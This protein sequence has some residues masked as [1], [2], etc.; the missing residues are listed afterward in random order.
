LQSIY[1]ESMGL[2][3]GQVSIM[4]AM[5]VLVGALGRIVVGAMTDRFGGRIMFSALLL[6]GVPAVLL[7]AVAGSIGSYP[8]LLV[9][10]F[11]LGIPGTIFAV[12]IPF[13]S[14][15]FAPHRR[16]FATG[17]FGMGMIG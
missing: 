8:L 15:W 12:G 10:A 17:V 5:P 9:A 16:G 6:M 13:S 2:D 14:A 1:S 4:L 11:I 7:V 3:Q